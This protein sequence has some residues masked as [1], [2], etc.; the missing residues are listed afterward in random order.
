[1]G[2]ARGR[3]SNRL[4]KF[5]LKDT[6]MTRFFVG[7]ETQS[8]MLLEDGIYLA[9]QFITILKDQQGILRL[10]DWYEFGG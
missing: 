6:K 3:F 1:M 2:Q 8:K 10:T 7:N 9:L 5:E 4:E